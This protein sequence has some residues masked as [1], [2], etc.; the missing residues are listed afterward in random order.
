MLRAFP[1]ITRVHFYEHATVFM[2]FFR[3][4][5]WA[6]EPKS[7]EAQAF[8]WQRLDEPIAETG[9]LGPYYQ[10]TLVKGP[11]YP[12]FI[13]ANLKLALPILFAQ[14]VMYLLGCGAIVAASSVL[15]RILGP[16]FFSVLTRLSGLVIVAVAVAVM[17]MGVFAHIKAF[18]AG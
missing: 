7:R 8:V 5:E 11:F 1:W 2:H 3:V 16:A 17:S 6:C 4:V 9:W 14:E 18:S 12:L 13:A 15:M 10:L